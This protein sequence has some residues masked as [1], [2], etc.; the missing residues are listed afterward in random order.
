[1]DVPSKLIPAI[2]D[3][4][5]E[6]QVGFMKNRQISDLTQQIKLILDACEVTE[7]NGVIVCLWYPQ[8]FYSHS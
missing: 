3:V 1:M 5:N 2:N 8:E 4:I 7:Q 6:D